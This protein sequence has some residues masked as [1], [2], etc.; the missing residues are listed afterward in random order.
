MRTSVVRLFFPAIILLKGISADAEALAPTSG[1][2]LDYREDQC[3]AYRQYGTAAAPVTLGIRPTPNGETYELLVSRPG[4]T[5]AL[6]ME[7]QGSINLGHGALPTW[8]LK[9]AGARG[10]GSIT[11][12]RISAAEMAQARS[13]AAVTFQIAAEPEL[14][15]PL[16]AMDDLLT[17]LDACNADLR[18]YWN[19][20]DEK[21]A[22]IKTPAKGDVKAVFTDDDYPLQALENGHEGSTQY[23]LMLNEKGGVGGCFVIKPS[24]VPAIDAIGCQVIR[25]RT[26]F[27]P[28]I[29]AEGRPIRSTYVTPPVK[30]KIVE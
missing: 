2:V 11:Q 27:T 30:W 14:T 4:S 25:A 13:A 8:V 20:T 28:A 9:Y 17:K 26:K 6:A 22:Q 7:L 29:D 16:S 24:G 21:K 18:D 10:K 19:A 15:F 23:F 3:L 12:F 5:A 1:W